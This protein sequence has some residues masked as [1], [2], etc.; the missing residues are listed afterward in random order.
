MILGLAVVCFNLAY[1]STQLPAM[2]LLIVGYA[3]F[4]VQLTNQPTVRRAFY[5]GLATGFA[6]AAVQAFFFAEIFKVAA[7]VLWIV[8]GFWIG[9][10]TAIFCGCIRR[11]GNGASVWL[12]P[13]IWTGTEYFRSELYY[14]RFSWLN[15]GYA[16]SNVPHIPFNDIGMYGAGFVVV[17]A[18]SALS[19]RPAAGNLSAVAI[20]IGLVAL[21]VFARPL[22]LPRQGTADGSLTIAGIQM[23]D[24]PEHVIPE[25]L[26]QALAKNPNARIFVLSEYTLDGGVPDSLKNWCRKHSRFLVVGGRDVVTNDVY[27]DTAFVIG[28]NGEMVFKQAKSV[29]IQFF[30]DGLPARQQQL[31]NSPWGKIGICICYDL[32]YTRVTDRLV[33][34]GAQMLIVP[35]MDIEDWGRHEH[36]LHSRVAPVRA[37]EYGIPVFRVAS[38]GISQAVSSQGAVIARTS[39]PGRGDILSAQMRLPSRGSIPIDRVIAPFCVIVTGAVTVILL[40]LEWG[41]R[42]PDHKA[43]VSHMSHKLV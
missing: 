9:L 22:L 23:E 29:P 18:V 43:V 3:G 11:W 15:I 35:S 41:D 38:S 26:N 34:D 28:T 19:F 2:A 1:A 20:C 37:A 17:L 10:F 27:Y 16:L 39:I 8:F 12:V 7:V 5:F 6:C 14:L 40:F 13:V 36:E 42:R 4:L 32:S 24:P 21:T 30:K 31:W 33:G 25:V